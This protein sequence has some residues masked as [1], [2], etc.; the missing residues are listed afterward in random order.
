M[1]KAKNP[2]ESVSDKLKLDYLSLMCKLRPDGVVSALK[3]YI[4]PLEESLKICEKEANLHGQA[5]I[6][7]R[8]RS[9]NDAI[10]IYIEIIKQGLSKYLDTST[11]TPTE[12]LNKYLSDALFS[13]EMIDEICKKE[14]EEMYEEGVGYFD[15][16]VN[17]LFEMYA[18]LD[19]KV[20]LPNQTEEQLARS[21]SL[22]VFV[23]S[24]IFDNFLVVYITRVGTNNL[25]NILKKI[26]DIKV[27]DF[28]EL[29]GTLHHEGGI[30]TSITRSLILYNRKQPRRL[31]RLAK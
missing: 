22:K 24:E 16:F 7:S 3:T 28:A 31:L 10:K 27:K 15:L 12:E 1:E 17:F 20:S 4:F 11:S 21:L 23:K 29:M 26:G 8:T 18:D 9:I 5:H 19:K 13:Y 2:S 6:K 30:I 14:I 25:I